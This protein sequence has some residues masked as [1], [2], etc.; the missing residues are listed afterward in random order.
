MLG[1]LSHEDDADVFGLAGW[2]LPVVEVV[3]Q[4]AVAHL[5]EQVFEHALVLAHLRHVEHVEV[6]GLGH[7][8]RIFKQ[9]LQAQLFVALRHAVRGVRNVN[10][11]VFFVI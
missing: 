11:V 3:M 2:H 4:F 6:V 8:E 7:D 10:L 1:R 5:E 9:L